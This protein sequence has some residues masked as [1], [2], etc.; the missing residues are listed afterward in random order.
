MANTV[1]ELVKNPR[2][3]VQGGALLGQLGALHDNLMDKI[4]ALLTELKNFVVHLEFNCSRSLYS[5]AKLAWNKCGL[6][7]SLACALLQKTPAPIKNKITKLPT[8]CKR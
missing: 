5:S 2:R 8:A 3:P 6:D 1:A 7:L 4:V